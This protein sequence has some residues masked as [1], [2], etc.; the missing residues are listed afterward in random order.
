VQRKGAH[1]FLNMTVFAPGYSGNK[2]IC[3]FSISCLLCS[4]CFAK[5]FSGSRMRGWRSR[6]H[7]LNDLWKEW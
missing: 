5:D 3:R 1:S 4:G 6:Q 7:Q 2:W